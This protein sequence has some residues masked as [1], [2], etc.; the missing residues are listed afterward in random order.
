MTIYS[1]D[2]KGKEDR[3]VNLIAFFWGRVANVKHVFLTGLCYV[4]NPR[5]Y[6]DAF[7]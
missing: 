3:K 6:G 5:I 7:E 1:K 2:C 4:P